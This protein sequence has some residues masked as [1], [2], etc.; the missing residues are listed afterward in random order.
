MVASLSIKNYALIKDIRVDFNSGLTIVTGET[1]AGKSIL[2]D[3]LS[4]VLGKR[5]D[6]KVVRNPLEKCIVEA[7]FHIGH[8]N[9]KD[10]FSRL[11]LDYEDHTFLRREILP[12]GKSRAFVNDTPASL[13]QV[14]TLGEYLIDIHSQFDTQS[15][16]SEKYQLEI[17][18]TLAGNENRLSEY[19]IA[20]REFYEVAERL[21]KLIEAKESAAKEWD[22]NQFLFEELKSVELSKI[23]QITLEETFEKLNNAE[24][25]QEVLSK[26]SQ[27]I[28]EENIGSLVTVTEIRLQLSKIKAYSQSYE[29]LWNR[30]NSL[31]I[32]LEDLAE[33][34]QD[35]AE[36]LEADPELLEQVNNTLQNLY[37]LQQKHQVSTIEELLHIEKELA[38]KVSDFET[39]DDKIS[40]AK[41]KKKDLEVSLKKFGE[42]I[43]EERKKVFPKLKE[44][45][46]FYLKDLG[47]PNAQFLFELKPTNQFRKNGTDELA[48][49]FSANKG[50]VPGPIQKIAS[51]GELSRVMLSLKAVT[52][53]FKN[54]P[55]II[56]DEID[57]GVSGEIAHKMALILS[58]MSKK[59]QLIS[60]THLP[61]IAAKGDYHKKVFKVVGKESTITQITELTLEER[62]VEIAQMI[63]GSSVS[64][65]AIAHAKQLLN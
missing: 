2:L 25:I 64:E 21:D 4:L 49:L 23:D 39:I 34:L 35:S 3:A 41:Q 43:H 1:G 44:K 29:D 46:E 33:E 19:T 60:I 62:I 61:Q 10:V 20:L 53:S 7:E 45:L 11:D 59:G 42:S 56:F 58:Q 55:T 22:Y 50:V 15:L 27:L 30:I 52:A 63:G 54:L 13:Q 38:L 36:S 9:L 47:L 14:Q 16:F 40:E 5:A 24:E 18:D 51:G 17:I 32:E 26:A 57:T 12:S 31:H 37:R 48:L 6:I 8:Y 28:F 65:S